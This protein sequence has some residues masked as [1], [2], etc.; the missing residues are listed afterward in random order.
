MMIYMPH[1]SGSDMHEPSSDDYSDVAVVMI[2]RDEEQAIGKVVGDVLAELPGCRVYVIDGSS[3]STPQLARA[4]GAVVIAEPGGGFGPALHAALSTPTEPIIATLDADDTY[5]VNMLPYMIHRVRGG[6]EVMGGSRLSWTGT[7]HM[8][9]S[10][11]IANLGFNVI[12]SAAARRRVRDVHSGMRVYQRH[13]L[14]SFD[15]RYEGMAFPVDLLLYPM[16]GGFR[17]EEIRID[18]H[19]RIGDSK[20]Q[21]WPSTKATLKRLFSAKGTVKGRRRSPPGTTA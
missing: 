1:W 12:A 21:K 16:L 5:P 17:V 9:V 19:E 18:Y 3:D 20:L 2:T 7:S 14:L 10:N 8:P 4:A 15:W 6:V 13:V 11:W